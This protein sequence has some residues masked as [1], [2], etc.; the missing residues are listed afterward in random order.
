MSHARGGPKMVQSYRYVE[1][2][3]ALVPARSQSKRIPRRDIRDLGGKPLMARTIEQARACPLVDRV[4]VSTDS[5][6]Y[7]DIARN[8]RAEAPFLRPAEISADESTDLEWFRHALI[9][10]AENEGRVPELIVHL[11]PTYP[12]RTRHQIEDAI[13]LLLDNP[14]WDSVRSVAPAPVSPYRMWF[15]RPDGSIEPVM[16]DGAM[17]RAHG[18]PRE[19]LPPVYVG[20][21][22]VDIIRARTILEKRSMAGDRVGALVMNEHREIETMED[23]RAAALAHRFGGRFPNDR[24]FCFGIDGVIATTVADD[25]YTRAQ[26]IRDRIAIINRLYESGNHI[27]VFTGRGSSTGLNWQEVTRLQLEDWGV[28]YHEL[29]FGKPMADYYVDDRALGVDELD[30]FRRDERDDGMKRMTG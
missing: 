13:L 16:A 10:L 29:R 25:N 22:C 14:D 8:F 3:L 9:W 2:I 1:R 11:R 26:P 27:V 6:R 15:P 5:P 24:T 17:I 12:G 21:G 30:A 18:E 7:A 19:I 28:R 23:F 20:N 4:I